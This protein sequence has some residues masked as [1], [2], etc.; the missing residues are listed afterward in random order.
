MLLLELV[1]TSQKVSS[2]ASRTEKLAHLSTLLRHAEPD[3]IGVV[4]AFLSGELRQR[5]IGLG[6]AAINAAH[7]GIGAPIS[8]LTVRDVDGAFENIASVKAGTG[9]N[10]ERIR[11]LREL[12]AR[13]TVEEQEFV[14]RLIFGELRQGALEGIMLDAVA[15]AGPVA[16]RGERPPPKLNPQQPPGGG[17]GMGRGAT[18]KKK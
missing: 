12:L 14:A 9:S 11:L 3:E 7:P 2:T 8:T 5:K 15:P 1:E 17:A 13:A 16:H 10:R 4:V 18:P 6:G